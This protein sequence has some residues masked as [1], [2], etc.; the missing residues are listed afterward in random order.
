MVLDS[1]LGQAEASGADQLDASVARANRLAAAGLR[2]G[3]A[4]QIVEAAIEYRRALTLG[5]DGDRRAGIEQNLGAAMCFVGQKEADPVQAAAAFELARRH[6]ESALTVRTRTDAPLAWALAQAN[7]AIVHLC[8]HRLTG[9][10]VEAMAG[11]IALDGA[12]EVFR[13]TRDRNWIDWI[14]SIRAQLLEAVDRRKSSR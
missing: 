1:S 13:E 2:T 6:L 8:V 12:Q 5:P 11:H 10:P 3:D 9:N 7:L 4:G 14:A